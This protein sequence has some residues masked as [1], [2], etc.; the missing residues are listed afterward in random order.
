[1]TKEQRDEHIRRYA[2]VLETMKSETVR[3][4]CPTS[5]SD[6]RKAGPQHKP[7]IATQIAEEMIVDGQMCN[8]VPVLV[9]GAH[10]LAA[11]K[12]LAWSHIDCIEVDD[13]DLRAELWEID[14]NLMRAELSPAEQAEHLSRRKEVWEALRVSEQ[15][16]PKR[17]G[18]PD[19]F[20]GESSTATG[21]TKQHINRQIA[22]AEALGPDLKVIAGTSLDKGVELD[23]LAKLSASQRAPIIAAA[24]AGQQVSARDLVEVKDALDV[25]KD[26]ADAIVRA[27]NR[28]CPEARQL[29]IPQCRIELTRP[30]NG[31]GET[32]LSSHCARINIRNGGNMPKKAMLYDAIVQIRHLLLPL[33][34][35]P[36]RNSEHA[37]L[38]RCSIT[39]G[40][41]AGPRPH[42]EGAR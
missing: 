33:G 27:W 32:F 30:C 26:Q 39:C 20:A 2:E 8:G 34:N 14:E 17:Q 41:I 42:T 12:A 7:G 15:N 6:G 24:A 1:M 21:Q 18:R 4:E 9:A 22:R 16:V 25:V 36:R 23:A 11:A 40:R 37:L 31:A 13:D 19:G 38:L 10:R 3:T 29:V 5:L 35:I 28:A